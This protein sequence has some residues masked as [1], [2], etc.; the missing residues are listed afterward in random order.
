MERV[1]VV[2]GGLA[3]CEAAVQLARRGIP[4]TLVEMKPK[5]RTP[6]QSSDGLCELVCSNSLR[7]AALSNA[8]GLLKEELRL[9]GSAVMECALAARVPAGG[10]LAVDR[11]R[12]SAG[13]M[14]LVR[15]TPG[16]ELACDEV[17]QIPEARPVIL[18]TGPLTS[19][20]LAADLARTVGSQHLAYYDAIAPIVEADSI[21]WARVWRQSRYDKGGD[22][23]VNC[24][25]DREGYEAFVRAIVAAEK[26]VPHDFEEV[27]YFEGCLPIEVMAERGL[28]T[29]RYGP[30]KPVGLVDPGTGKR[31]HAVVQLRAEDVAGTAY[32]LVGFQSRMT[33]PEQ[34]RVFRMIPGLEQAEFVRLGAIHRNTFVDAPTLLDRTMQLRGAE[35]VYLAGQISGVEGYIE[36]AAG[37]FLCGLMLAQRLRGEIITPPPPTTALG[38]L[39]THLSRPSPSGSYQPSNVTWAQ[40]PPLEGAP[41]LKKR[42]RYQL[43]AK[44]GQ[45]DFAPWLATIGSPAPSGPPFAPPP[46]DD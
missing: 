29:L 9:A 2:G 40:V 7:G 12:F 31:P 6:A 21:D 39:L 27:R 18:A 23:Y 44:R 20:A 8:V 25:F 17:Q 33:W 3:G 28:D 1:T 34:K 15:S 13:M 45:E 32:N 16:L 26:V 43:L 37:G 38:A 35:G 11:E 4:V 42:D 30:L 5:K 24:G 14:Q 19:D 41:R 10:A 22:D 36:S 46:S